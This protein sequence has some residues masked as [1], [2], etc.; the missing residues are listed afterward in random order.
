MVLSFRHLPNGAA[1]VGRLGG[2]A[3]DK[4]IGADPYRAAH[5]AS[6]AQAEVQAGGLML[7]ED[8]AR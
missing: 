7:F 3:P 8:R 6:P 2:V 5:G 4:S 1:R